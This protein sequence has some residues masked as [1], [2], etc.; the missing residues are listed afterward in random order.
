[1]TACVH[2]IHGCGLCL[3]LEAIA[4]ARRALLRT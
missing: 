3:L 4:E 1:M 2:A